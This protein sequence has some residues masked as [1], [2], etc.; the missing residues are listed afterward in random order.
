MTPP[1]IKICGVTLPDDAARVAAAGVDFIGLNFWPRS[2]RFVAPERAPLLAAAARASGAAKLV[3]VF[4]DATLEQ[5][6][7]TC[8]RVE[9]D[10]IQLHG[11]ERADACSR[12]SGAL[13]RPVWKALPIADRRDLDGLDHWQVDALLLDAP[14]TGR[15]GSGARFDHQLAREARERYPA[16]TFV[17]AGGLDPANVAAAIALVEPWAVDVASGV[18]VAPGVKDPAKLA[19][20]VAAVRGSAK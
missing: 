18:E 8:A 10:I 3:G 4:V 11:D 17:L 19:A 9:L 15:G 16:R 20:F 12:V 1:R 13:Y 6:I 2:K 14:S 5:I 7:A